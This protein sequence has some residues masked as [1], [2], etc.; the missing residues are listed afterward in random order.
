MQD[1]EIVALY[2]DRNEDAIGQTNTKYGAYCRK[3]AMNI[4]KNREDA[5]EV[6]NDTWLQAWKVIPPEKPGNLLAFLTVIARANAVDLYR[7][8]HSEKRTALLAV[9]R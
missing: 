8:K 5:E 6:L 7:K 9:R 4:L 2:W 1:H 3:I